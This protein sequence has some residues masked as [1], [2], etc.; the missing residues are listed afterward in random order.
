[1]NI[2]FRKLISIIL[3]SCLL[4]TPGFVGNAAAKALKEGSLSNVS[5][6][7]QNDLRDKVMQDGK[8][9]EMQAKYA[10]NT[11]NVVVKQFPEENGSVYAVRIPIN[12]NTGYQYSSYTVFF[13]KDC[14]Q[15]EAVLF[16]FNK[17]EDG[18]YQFVAKTSDSTVTANILENGKI[19]NAEKI[20][21]SGVGQ[22]LS[23]ILEYKNQ[24]AN[25]S[26]FAASFLTIK[27][28]IAAGFWSCFNSC[29]AGMGVP[30]WAITALSVACSAICIGTAGAACLLCLKAA[31]VVLVGTV[32]Y[33]FGQCW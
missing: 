30:A 27:T 6:E 24:D 1:M 21:S 32:T 14:Q 25:A 20:D 9:K 8:F 10:F 15:K 5:V 18:I 13:D 29:L 11:D 3:V 33:C 19:L 12:D 26:G 7:I 23:K 4:M 22:D 16:K 31:E 2:N 28:A 17:L